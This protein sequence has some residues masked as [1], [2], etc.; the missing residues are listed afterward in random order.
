MGRGAAQ[1]ANRKSSIVNRPGFTLI[2]LLVVIAV[3][4][5]LLAALLPALGR[6]RKV[7][8]AAVCQGRLR[9]WGTT[10]GLYMENNDGRFPTHRSAS[11]GVWLLRGAVMRGDDPNAD[12]AAL[13]GFGTREVVCCPTATRPVA[14]MTVPFGSGAFDAP[15]YVSG[16]R[17][18]GTRGAASGAWEI[19]T[20]APSFRGSYGFNEWLF[21]GFSKYPRT[22]Q[23]RLIGLH[24]HSFRRTAIIPVLLDAVAPGAQPTD[25]MFPSLSEEGWGPDMT[26]FC[27][28]RHGGHVNG[29]FLDW[30]VRKVGL[31]ELWTLDWCLEF[32]RAGR[33]TKAGGVKPEDWPQWI[34]GF[35]DY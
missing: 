33:W 7:A 32:D 28:N 13:H 17:V 6:A 35:R 25:S 9:Q 19:T 4:G 14:G 30:S 18:T 24:A 23:G 16:V 11:A 34:R 27:I 26:A 1:F 10:L 22:R 20:P 12:C 29:L 2:E 31:K 8:R 15:D 21:R 3:I 5:L